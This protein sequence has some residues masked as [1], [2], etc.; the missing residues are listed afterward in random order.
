MGLLYSFLKNSSRVVLPFF[1]GKIDVFGE[2][3]IPK[4]NPYILA[5]NHQNSFIDAIILGAYSTK[6]VTF[7]ARSDVFV[8]P[9]D[10]ILAA[11]KL[12]PVYR[13]RDGYEKLKLNEITFTECDKILEK[14]NPVLIFPESNTAHEFY[15]RPITKGI[16]RMAFQSQAKLEE[17]L[18]ILPVGLNYGHHTFPF[19][20]FILN[21]GKPVRVKDFIELHEQHSAKGLISIR[22]AISAGMKST[23]LIPEKD[24]HYPEKKNILNRQYEELSFSSLKELLETPE[25][26]QEEGY[27]RILVP[28]TGVLMLPNMPPFLLLYYL[29]NRL[30]DPQFI[31]SYKFVFALLIF[32]IWWVAIFS[33]VVIV[34]SWQWA[35]I[36]FCISFA[37]IFIRQYL[38]KRIQ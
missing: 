30:K 9:Y 26:I 1:F 4:D 32:P 29:L 22:N 38:R 16:S 36:I 7:L 21:Y 31:L 25:Q 18:Y 24:E 15:L 2:E 14:G 3:N 27:N 13:M 28:I 6:P 23:L 17:D 10:K 20:R 11:L 12:M 35:T 33:L 34:F 5:P 19:H 8:P 37:S